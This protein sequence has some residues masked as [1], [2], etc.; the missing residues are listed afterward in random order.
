MLMRRI[1]FRGHAW[2]IL[3]ATSLAKN[4]KKLFDVAYSFS[5]ACVLSSCTELRLLLQLHRS[6]KKGAK[7]ARLNCC[8]RLKL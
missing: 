2:R 7:M 8:V 5:L 6:F 3:D 1:S 4:G